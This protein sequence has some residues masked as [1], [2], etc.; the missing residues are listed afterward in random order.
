MYTTLRDR[1]RPITSLVIDFYF[2]IKII[3]YITF[4]PITFRDLEFGHHDFVICSHYDNLDHIQFNVPLWGCSSIVFVFCTYT[5]AF[6]LFI[7]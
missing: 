3:V 4:T 6:Y 7:V 5:Y 1:M 2:Y